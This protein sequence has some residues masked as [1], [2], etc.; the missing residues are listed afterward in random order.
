MD[1]NVVALQGLYV[2]LGGDIED[3]KDINVIPD[4]INAIATLSAGIAGATLPAV[5]GADDG[6]ILKV[7]DG[8]WAAAEA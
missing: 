3:V 2:A 7:V 6:K 5:T 8:A 4:M 1:T